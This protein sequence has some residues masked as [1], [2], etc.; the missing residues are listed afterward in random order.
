MSEII[1]DIRYFQENVM[2]VAFLTSTVFAIAMLNE[3]FVFCYHGTVL[4]E[5][6][7]KQAGEYSAAY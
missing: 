1:T 2:S 4:Y 7:S 3:L 5:E 6:V